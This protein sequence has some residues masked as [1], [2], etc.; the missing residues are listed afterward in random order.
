MKAKHIINEVS[1]IMANEGETVESIAKKIGKPKQYVN[2]LKRR[3]KNF[4]LEEIEAIVQAMGY[5]LEIVFT[6]L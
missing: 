5:N 2:D 4:S 3:E 1:K 6:K